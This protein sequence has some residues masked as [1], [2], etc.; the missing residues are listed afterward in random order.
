MPVL[1][2]I[3]KQSIVTKIVSRI[4]TP[5][6]VLSR[7]FG[8]ERGGRN[9]QQVKIPTPQYTYDIFDK[10]RKVA[11]GRYRG[12]PAGSIAPQTVGNNTV[13]LCRFAQKLPMDYTTI[14]SIRTLGENA[15]TTDRM[16]KRYIEKQAEYNVQF[17]TNM[18]EM[19][20]GSLL[21]GGLLY[22]F[23]VGDDLIPSYTSASASFSNDLKIATEHQLI[24]G[25]FAAGLQMYTGADCITATWATASND[26]PRML[27]KVSAGF[28]RG[29][30]EPLRYVICNNS[31]WNNVLQNTAVRQLAG[32]AA[33]PFA[34]WDQGEYKSPDGTPLGVKIGRIKGMSDI[35]FLI[36]EHGLDVYDGTSAETYTK[37]V[38]DDYC[39]FCVNPSDWLVGVEGTE[40][41][42]INDM[43]PAQEV[44]GDFSWIMEKADPARFELHE[45]CNYAL[46]LNRPKALAI[47]RV[48]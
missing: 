38:P 26:I 4:Q 22:F 12:V 10:T 24:A 48:Q 18:R 28:E 17:M 30:G 14:A 31:V 23:A 47:A 34:Q 8:V 33:E 7:F 5:G 19:F 16:G 32:S 45:V 36:P 13:T 27:Q 40:V 11:R 29:V 42:K 41:V 37:I 1:Q 15:G 9:V 3:L 43:A 39:L 6:A 21:R 20:T 25:S 46:E 2:E 35:G 44:T